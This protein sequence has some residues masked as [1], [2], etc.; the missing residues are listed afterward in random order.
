MGVSFF[1]DVDEFFEEHFEVILLCS[2]II[3]IEFVLRLFS[4]QI[5][6]ETHYL[7]ISC[8]RVSMQ[9]FL[10]VMPLDFDILCTHPMFGLE[11]GQVRLSGLPFVYE[12]VRVGK[13]KEENVLI[14][15]LIYLQNKVT[16]WLR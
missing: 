10:H 15:F 2:F 3:E 1:K 11:N 13:E 12:K 4:T 9:L 8:Q 16:R 5:L 6:R 7:H 14:H